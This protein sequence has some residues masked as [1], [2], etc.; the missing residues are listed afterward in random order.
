MAL[1][2][3]TIFASAGFLGCAWAVAAEGVR[4]DWADTSR[5]GVDLV[6]G[7]AWVGFALVVRTRT[8]AR[9]AA[10]L[11]LA[12]SGT[13]FL[14]NF[15]ALA[16]PLLAALAAQATYLHR[17]VLVHLILTFPGAR[18]VGRATVAV[19]AVA[20]AL[21]LVPA[22]SRS[23]P[24]TLALWAAVVA[25]ATA[26]VRRSAGRARELRVA[27]LASALLLMLAFVAATA[28]RAASA[29]L[30]AVALTMYD[31]A[32]VA[33]GAVLTAGAVRARRSTAVADLVVDLADGPPATMADALARAIGDP[34]LRVGYWSPAVGEF[35]DSGGAPLLLAPGT[36]RAVSVVRSHEGPLLA[37]DH[38]ASTMVAAGLQAS[39]EDAASLMA[40]NARLHAQLRERLEDLVAARRRLV[41]AQ[42]Q[43]RRDLE[44]QL[45]A[46]AGRRLAAVHT[47][48]SAV[49]AS[50]RPRVAHEAATATEQL[51]RVR[52]ELDRLARGLYPSAL[53]RSGLRAALVELAEDLPVPVVVSVEGDV[54]AALEE[55]VWFVCAEA[56]TNVVKHAGA[57]SAQVS[58]VVG[59]GRLLVDVT[60]DGVGLVD[61]GTG[62][63][64]AAV[65]GSGLSGLADRVAAFGGELVVE[66]VSPTGLRLSVDLPLDQPSGTVAGSPEVSRPS[67]SG[68]PTRTAQPVRAGRRSGGRASSG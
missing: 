38:D 16:S 47:S 1:R 62:V 60:D 67:S 58:V 37:L 20:Y 19:V 63:A 44:E 18:P 17:G 57:S 59:D 50:A 65:D 25:V 30:D 53:G 4:Y 68:G 29:T 9:G 33:A 13:W 61:G 56:L 26:R 27:A 21:S 41:E 51:E 28:V 55:V 45:R 23:E 8:P 12:F 49:A 22:L 31:L 40:G 46:G 3:T 32:V 48:L 52:A 11:M 42:V 7:L 14:G 36:G 2:R 15:A 10:S 34:T 6:V 64:G 66:E 39:L 24:V 35:V 54:P 43:E 5:W